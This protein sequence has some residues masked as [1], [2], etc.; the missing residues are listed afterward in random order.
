M[1]RAFPED[2]HLRLAG[3]AENFRRSEAEQRVY[4]LND[5]QL[6]ACLSDAE[7][8]R[9]AALLTDWQAVC[10]VQP[11]P[12]CAADWDARVLG[13]CDAFAARAWHGPLTDAERDRLHTIYRA[14]IEASR[15]H[16]ATH[17]ICQGFS[18]YLGAQI[19]YE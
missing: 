12:D 2:H 13:H 18:D 15:Y 19:S 3:I 8:E 7:R 10:H 17:Q 4:H 9:H 14:G 11:P 5:G 1:R 16:T 6:L